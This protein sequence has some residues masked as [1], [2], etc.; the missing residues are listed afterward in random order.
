MGYGPSGLKD[1]DMTKVTQHSKMFVQWI[2]K[3]DVFLPTL[4]SLE[5]PH[6][7][8]R[9][10]SQTLLVHCPLSWR[11]L[12]GQ[13]LHPS[14]RPNGADGPM[15]FPTGARACLRGKQGPFRMKT[16]P[17]FKARFG[18][19]VKYFKR[20]NVVWMDETNFCV[21]NPRTRCHFFTT[22]FVIWMGVHTT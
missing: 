9:A 22:P 15:E 20:V 11:F 13:M 1:S 10:L 21:Q 18:E 8:R 4:H 5:G 16:K 12:Q 6:H 2:Y 19:K 17:V 14:S 7:T 3:H